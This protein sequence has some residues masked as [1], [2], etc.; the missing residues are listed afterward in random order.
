MVW[1]GP[2][3]EAGDE[4]GELGE[5]VFGGTGFEDFLFEGLVLFDD[6]GQ[7]GLVGFFVV[8]GDVLASVEG[9]HS[10]TVHSLYLGLVPRE[11]P[12]R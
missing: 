8:D 10:A 6:F 1:P 2:L 4:G 5:L 12:P 7:G 9:I 3:L 11:L